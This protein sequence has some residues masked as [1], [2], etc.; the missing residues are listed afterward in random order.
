MHLVGKGETARLLRTV[1]HVGTA[2]TVSVPGP[3][4]K[5]SLDQGPPIVWAGVDQIIDTEREHAFESH[6]KR[7]LGKVDT[8]GSQGALP[9]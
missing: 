7:F 6:L 2:R 3:D 4:T 9:C 5:P 8:R 1:G